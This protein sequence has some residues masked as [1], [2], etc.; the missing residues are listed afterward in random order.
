MTLKIVLVLKRSVAQQLARSLR[1]HLA[2]GT[3]DSTALVFTNEAGGPVDPN[4]LRRRVLKPLVQ[5]VGAPWAGFHTF[6]HTFASMHLSNGTN[7]VQLS[8]VL[9]HHSPAFTLS[10]YTHLL[11]GEAVPA[12][13]LKS[14]DEAGYIEDDLRRLESRS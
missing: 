6:R 7:I 12:L 10:R 14:P 2:A 8:H 13:E 9:G 4:N 5:E 3:D 1:D 11:P